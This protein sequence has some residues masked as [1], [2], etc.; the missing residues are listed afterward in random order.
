[1]AVIP[2]TGETKGRLVTQ[3][4]GESEQALTVFHQYHSDAVF[5]SIKM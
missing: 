2:V 4:L 5:M 1:V 3:F